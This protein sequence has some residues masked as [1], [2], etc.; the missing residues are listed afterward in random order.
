[1]SNSFVMCRAGP[2]QLSG[3]YGAW[4]TVRNDNWCGAWAPIEH[5][6]GPIGLVEKPVLSLPKKK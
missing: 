4:P 1:M 3:T 2:P 5:K 6:W